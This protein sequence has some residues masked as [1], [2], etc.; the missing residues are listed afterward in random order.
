MTTKIAL[1]IED[2]LKHPEKYKPIA[3][4][5]WM[6]LCLMMVLGSMVPFWAAYLALKTWLSS[7][8]EKH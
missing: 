8:E 3:R 1:I 5:P 4:G 7:D 6:A 2:E